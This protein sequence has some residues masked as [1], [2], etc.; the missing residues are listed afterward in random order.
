MIIFITFI[1]WII[2]TLFFISFNK[3]IN[4]L[5][6]FYILKI[7]YKIP[8]NNIFYKI[9]RLI[10]QI[11]EK[12]LLY[13]VKKEVINIDYSKYKN[14]N[15]EFDFFVNKIKNNEN[16]SLSRYQDWEYSY[17]SW[18]SVVAWEWWKSPSYIWNFW[19]RLWNTLDI[20]SKNFYYWISDPFSD[21]TSYNFLSSKIINKKNITIWNIFTWKNSDRLLDFFSNFNSD[22][23]LICNE[24]WKNL[25][26]IWKFKIQNKF[27]VKNTADVFFDKEWENF[28]NN[29][30][31]VVKSEENKIF[32]FASWPL[33]NIFIY[34]CFKVNPNNIYLDIWSSFDQIIHWKKTRTYMNKKS[35]EYNSIYYTPKFYDEEIKDNME[36]WVTVIL[37]V[38]RRQKNLNKQIE[39]LLSQSIKPKEIIILQNYYE[40][41][42][43]LSDDI[44][45][46]YKVFTCSKNTWVWWRFAIALLSKTK[47]I[48]IFDDDTIP[49][50][51]WIENCITEYN[52]K[53]W[54][55]WT[56]GLIYNNT[57]EYHNNSRV[58]WHNNSEL[59]SWVTQEVDIVWHSW[60]FDREM[61]TKYWQDSEVYLDDS[62]A[63]EDMHFSYILQKYMNLWT[64][65]P[66]HPFW[67]KTLWWSVDW[68]KY[69][70]DDVALW[71]N[72]WDDKF[73][74][75]YKKYINKWFKIL[76][77]K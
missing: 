44:K 34:E 73:E 1:L 29:L 31:D 5:F 17:I 61:L 26:H 49:W 54:L 51:R 38:F 58:W 2:F 10:L 50:N 48:C 67:D 68:E 20:N 55:Y 53:R 3:K 65:V 66:P 18:K 4:D 16:F 37:N 42:S 28:L 47:F 56:I 77:N 9:V 7:F 12:V 46:K 64:Y 59:D 40:W 35:K 19:K 8:P 63:W 33:S 15:D 36:D 32:L 41:E 70:N 74:K 13:I 43:E 6:L 69:G 45:T 21:E 25:T 72:W 30:L 75:I 11:L 24:K 62:L 39:S 14:S 52:K 57:F 22:W 76:K 71:K 27:L 60:F 23:F